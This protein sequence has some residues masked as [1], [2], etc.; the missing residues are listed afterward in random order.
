VSPSG[1]GKAGRRPRLASLWSK[2]RARWTLPLVIIFVIGLVAVVDH[3]GSHR[4]RQV[5]ALSTSP[6]VD[7]TGGAATVDLDHPWSG[8]NPNTPAGAGSSTPTL[9]SSVLPSAYVINPKLIPEVNSN[10]LVSV[11]ATS[12][13]P[14]IIQYVINP[15]AVWSD[16]VP[17]SADDFYYAWQSQKGDGLDVTGRPDQVASTLGYRD[18]ASVTPSDG[19]KTVTVKFSAPYTDWRDMFDHMVPAHIAR[20]VGWNNGFDDFS[21]AIDLS[22]GPLMVQSVSPTGTAVLVRNPHWW[23]IPAIV[24]KVTVNVAPSAATWSGTLVRGSRAVVQPLDVDLSSLDAVSSLP[25]TESMVKPSLRLLDLELN[26]ASPLM[27]RVAARQ[28]VAHAIDRTELLN[29]TFGAIE[30]DLVVNQDHLATASQ[31]A[32]AASSAAGEYSTRDAPTT[33]RLL[34]SIG[35]HQN[36]SGQYVDASGVPLTLRMAV[37]TGDPWIDAVASEISGQLHQLGIGVQTIPMGSSATLAAAAASDTYDMA[38]VTRLSS[39]FQ[40]VTAAWY[41]DGQGSIGSDGTEDWSNFDDPQVDQLFTQAAQALN[42]VTG[43]AIYGQIDDQLWDQ[44][45]SLPLF[46]EPGFE[47]NGV[48]LANAQYNPSTDG[49]LWNVSLWTTLKPGPSDRQTS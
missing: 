48:Q 21:P 47:A 24:D 39:P 29:R 42:P 36:L 1:A 14:L 6:L 11:E 23:G 5:D 3:L 41:S 19:G 28:A 44:M 2:H 31:S 17:F 7:A 38:L 9:L 20:L 16:G 15:R 8:F 32:Y 45:V 35:Y 13:T 10:L 46:A 25:A 34:R 43:G 27:S 30:P 18:V 33:D 26:V 37:L 40:T 49:I 12:T 22:A 4:I